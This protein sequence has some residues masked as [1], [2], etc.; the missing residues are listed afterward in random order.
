MLDLDLDL[1]AD[2]GID[3][4]KRIE[5][6]GNFQLLYASQDSPVSEK[7]MEKL[8]TIRTLRGIID[9]LTKSSRSASAEQ[10]ASHDPALT[11]EVK[12]AEPVRGSEAGQGDESGGEVG[13]DRYTLAPAEVAPCNL[14]ELRQI[15]GTILLTDDEFGIA[16]AL[17]GQLLARGDKVA[18]VRLGSETAETAPGRYLADLASAEGAAEVLSLVRQRQGPIGGLVHLLPLKAGQGFPEMDLAAW[19][20]ELRLAVKSL[21]YL[22]RG[23]VHEDLKNAA[24]QGGA[25]VL[26]ATRMGGTFA[27]DRVETSEFFPGQ[28]GVAGL[29]KTLAREWPDV[30]VKVVDLN[31]REPS[32][33]VATHLFQELFTADDQI[34]VGYQGQRRLALQPIAVPV[35]S[36]GPAALTI[37]SSWVILVTGGARGI[38]AEVARF[39]AEHYRP[40]LLLIGRSPLPPPAESPETAGL[41]T[42][43]VLKAALMARLGGDGHPAPLSQVEAAYTRL[44]QDREI[45][46]NIAAME[47]AGATVHY[48]SV[49]VRDEVAFSELI[50]R[51]YQT[52]GRIDGVIHGAGVIEDKLVKDKAPASFHRVFDTKVDAALILSRKLRPDSLKALVFF[53]SVSGIF[54]NRGQGD[55]AAANEV[56]N[57]LAL[58]LDRRWPGR[59]VSLNWGP[60]STGMVSS[61]LERQ[62]VARGIE[63]IPPSAG[64]RA[65]DKELRYGKKGDVVVLLTAGGRA[66]PPGGRPPARTRTGA[67]MDGAT[68]TGNGRTG[69]EFIRTLDPSLDLYLQDHQLSGKPVLPMAVGCELMAEA[70]SL[71]FPELELVGMRELKVLRGIVLE[72]GPRAVRILAK[73]LV[74]TPE[75]AEV[76]VTIAATEDPRRVHYRAVAELALGLPE[77]PRDEGLVLR[78]ARPFP[79]SVNDAYRWLFHG[80]RLRGIK[81]VSGVTGEGIAG[82]IRPSSPREL[83][84]HATDAPWL[85][86]PVVIDSALQLI[87]FWL[88]M[89]WDVAALPSGFRGFRRFGHL[90]GSPVECRA[91]IWGDPAHIIMHADVVFVGDGGR[92][93][94]VL[95]DVEGT[96]SKSLVQAFESLPGADPAR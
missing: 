79:L 22:A 82:S 85:I 30:R 64:C 60:W 29:T 81:T 46:N 45:R 1:E 89:H 10:P 54:G 58:H 33:V 11:R 3:S 31:P 16:E 51:M 6:L 24:L 28:G 92:V 78:D 41:T 27:V 96:C 13:L 47:R 48:C 57:K 42:P 39:L 61:E 80:P 84:A 7:E 69:L 91:R 2:L 9:W 35:R 20:G 52:H 70:A 12:S 86:D 37:E 53:S 49:D 83:L 21:F 74:M 50:D 38:T 67:M 5:I 68:S 88:R 71:A 4:I 15:S 17:A 43:Q 25:C 87:L 75:R 66:A 40:T 14:A 19:R 76:E 63:L 93:L 62:F 72:D 18:L 59:V 32:T 55:Y 8:T 44:L 77:P 95:E 73:P 26:A 23:G 65:M 56:L 90:S 34:E 36:D 94:G